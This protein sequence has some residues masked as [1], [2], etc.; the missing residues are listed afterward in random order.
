M[1][2]CD[3]NAHESIHWWASENELLVGGVIGRGRKK[4]SAYR[5]GDHHASSMFNVR[6]F[7]LLKE[8]KAQIPGVLFRQTPPKSTRSGTRTN[9]GMHLTWDDGLAGPLAATRRRLPLGKLG[10]VLGWLRLC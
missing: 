10:Q 8:S 6:Q 2:R 7:I 5:G 3:R 9:S 1:R 4:I